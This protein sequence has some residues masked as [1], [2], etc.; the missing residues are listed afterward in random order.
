[1]E[2]KRVQ[3]ENDAL[4]SSLRHMNDKY[5]VV[6]EHRDAQIA[7]YVE[8]RKQI[9]VEVRNCLHTLTPLCAEQS[10]APL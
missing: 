1:M 8:E 10:P 3:Q 5:E 2:N 4:L 9:W 7:K 6:L